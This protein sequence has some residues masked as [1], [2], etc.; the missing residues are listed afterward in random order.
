[1]VLYAGSQDYELS[2]AAD[3]ANS[4]RNTDRQS[5][6]Q[7]KDE[8]GAPAVTVAQVLSAVQQISTQIDDLQQQY[9]TASK[10]ESLCRIVEAAKATFKCTL[11]LDVAKP[12]Y[13]VHPSCGRFIGCEAC[14][15][16]MLEHGGSLCPLCRGQVAPKETFMRLNGFDEIAKVLLDES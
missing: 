6:H 14:V 15:D 13:I 12:P 3:V 2:D 1:M 16:R 9:H 4:S 7:I 8:E 11:C 5:T 10:V